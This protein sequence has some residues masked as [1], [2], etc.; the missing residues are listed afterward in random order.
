MN[1]T[2]EKVNAAIV[3]IGNEILSGR[4]QD[5]NVQFIAKKLKNNGIILGEVRIVRDDKAQ[6]VKNIRELKSKYNYVFTTGGI[7][8]THDDITAECV[9]KAFN[10]K[11]VI[12]KL[13]FKTLEKYFLS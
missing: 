3:I 9:A 7:G 1:K 5:I 12:N 2:K 8:P 13:A 11:Y 10:R 6:I 4:T